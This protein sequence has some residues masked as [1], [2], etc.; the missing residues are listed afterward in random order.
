V[1]EKAMTK[2]GNYIRADRLRG[3]DFLT[4]TDE[5]GNVRN[6]SGELLLGL[7]RAASDEVAERIAEDER[8]EGLIQQEALIR[9][10]GDQNQTGSI[11]EHTGNTD[12]HVTLQNKESWNNKHP[13]GGGNIDFQAKKLTAEELSPPNN[14]SE[15]KLL[16]ATDWKVSKNG[17]TQVIA[18]QPWVTTYIANL[19]FSPE[20]HTH[21]SGD[22][23]E[24]SNLPV[25]SATVAGVVKVG[26][27]L[28]VTEGV[29]NV[30]DSV[31][32]EL[33]FNNSNFELEISDG[34]SVDL[35]GL[36]PDLSGY[37]TED[38][39]EENFSGGSYPENPE[40]K[41]VKLY[42][43]GGVL[44]WTIQNNDTNDDLVFYNA[45]GVKTA[46][47]DQSGNL[48]AVGE[49]EAFSTR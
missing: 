13:L 37:A 3:S 48:Y 10:Q 49:V 29:L 14:T 2:I 43:E 39:V 15:A 25:A 22:I 9:A 40:L 34:N 46:M 20:E 28:S 36:I 32:Q 45:S 27:L 17:V 24:W 35:S 44:K 47:I 18:T 19:D 26:S 6:F 33:S 38:W 41:S 1:I 4:G 23:T 42:T 12:I 11:A 7:R 5:Q 21:T 30:D 16:F 8:L 31:I